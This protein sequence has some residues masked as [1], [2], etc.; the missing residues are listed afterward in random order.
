MVKFP[1]LFRYGL[2]MWPGDKKNPLTRRPMASAEQYEALAAKVAKEQYP[3]IDRFEI[4]T[5]YAIPKSWLSDLAL[6]TQVVVKKSPLCYAHG[7]VL[8]SALSRYLETAPKSESV[9]ILETGTARGFSSL[10]MARALADMN[11]VGKV[12]T[13]DTLPHRMPIYWNCID[14]LERKKSRQELL[15][16]WED[17]VQKYLIF[18]QGDTRT[19]LSRV[20]IDRVHFAFLD[21]AH[22]RADV[23]LEFDHIAAQQRSGDVV[24]FDDYTPTQYPGIVAAVNEICQRFNYVPEKIFAHSGR[25]YV[26]AVK[27]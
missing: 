21:G 19:T 5:G 8:Y 2:S 14:D 11:R 15:K 1:E 18:I 10:C 17:L 27:Q 25:G 24:L 7:R 6:H 23:R 20:N 13:F 12:V 22:D 4:E 26:V 3:E 9:N 16:P